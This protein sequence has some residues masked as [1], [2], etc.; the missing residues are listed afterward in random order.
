LIFFAFS[1]FR[2]ETS[3]FF[4]QT[5]TVSFLSDFF[6]DEKVSNAFHQDIFFCLI[7][8]GSQWET[9][10]VKTLQNILSL[11]TT[12][13][14]VSGG[15]IRH[16]VEHFMRQVYIKALIKYI[17]LLNFQIGISHPLRELLTQGAAI[18]QEN[19]N[20]MN[21]SGSKD[22]NLPIPPIRTEVLEIIFESLTDIL[23][24]DAYLPSLY[25]S[26]DCNPLAVDLVQPLIQLISRATSI[27]LTTGTEKLGNH[28]D[29]GVSIVQC[30]KQLIHAFSRRKALAE[31]WYDENNKRNNST[32]LP[33][34]VK[35]ISNLFSVARLSKKILIE[36]AEKFLV[37]PSQC[38][39]FLQEEGLLPKPL[40]TK[41]CANFLRQNIFLDK[42][43]VGAFIGELGKPGGEIK[44]ECESQEFHASLLKDYVESFELSDLK[45]LDAMRLFLSAFRLPGEAQQIDRILNS[46]ANYC[47]ENCIEKSSSIIENNEIT[48]LLMFSIIM[49]NTDL[50][51]PNIKMEKKMT[52]S[53]FLKTNLNYGRDV[54]QTI[55]L[56]KEYL[57]NIYSSINEH[58]IRTQGNDSLALVTDEEWMDLNMMLKTN[59]FLTLLISTRQSNEVIT[60]LLSH[61]SL[62]QKSSSFTE[63]G[64]MV[65]NPMPLSIRIGITPESTHE[66]HEVSDAKEKSNKTNSNKAIDENRNAEEGEEE[67]HTIYSVLKGLFTSN[68]GWYSTLNLFSLFKTVYGLDWFMDRDLLSCTS[69]FVLLPGL[70]VLIYNNMIV[71]ET[72]YLEETP[73]IPVQDNHKLFEWKERTGRLMELSTDFLMEVLHIASK[74]S[75]WKVIDMAIAILLQI[76]GLKEV[77]NLF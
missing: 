37:K 25:A 13:I 65:L 4:Q 14:A 43:A 71:E 54:N 20:Q 12:L 49:L 2:F 35:N 26:F 9:L 1:T 48:Y 58:Q 21:N 51:N 57:E 77:N 62:I 42:T 10:P 15:L 39:K 75:L 40:T 47:Y 24:E 53:Q 68:H 23:C 6:S 36:S 38:F 67:T 18:S 3:I 41:L 8:I 44:H 17:E 50:H 27:I 66:P 70:S 28:K 59:P 16:V 7:N 30:Y 29:L 74:H 31:Q 76:S 5:L 33:A 63:G 55:P 60:Q 45:I 72:I 34:C 64:E 61:D 73:E 52:L 22:P 56:P 19:M 69:S 32:N 11:F 46:F